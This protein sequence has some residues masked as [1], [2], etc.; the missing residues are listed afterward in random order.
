[1]R[2]LVSCFSENSINVTN[3]SCSN[4]SSN[5][6]ISP[7]LSPSVQTSITSIYRITLG[8]SSPSSPRKHVLINVTWCKNN[9]NST[10]HGLSI[11]VFSDENNPSTCLKLN[12]TSRFFRKKKGTKVLESDL[13]KIEVF[14]D[15]AAAKYDNLGGPEPVE[16]FYVIVLVDAELGLVLG[17]S[18]EEA[19]FKKLTKGSSDDFSSAI[20]KNCLISRQE[21]F[22]GN[23]LYSTRAKFAETGVFHEILIRCSGETE[24][25]K[26]STHNGHHHH[27]H[28]HHP[29]LSVCIDKK[30]VIKV[31]RLQWNFRGNQTIFLDGLLVDLMWDV[32]DW[33]FRSNQESS[34]SPGSGRAVFMFRTRSGMDSRLWL[35]EKI[36]KKEQD[37][38]DFSLLI[39]ACKT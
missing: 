37:N 33:F 25:L 2:D 24:G 3:P 21:H 4:Y 17:D 26:H 34:S 19:L 18:A 27:H 31:K 30:T 8:S 29:V 7:D 20:S 15:L 11:G 9:T 23:T 14:W 35:E 36:V 28:H 38:L 32:H 22:S 39:Y 12:T 1:M 16:G 6:C 5:A 13:G 10:N